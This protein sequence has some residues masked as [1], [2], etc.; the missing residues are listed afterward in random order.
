MP[1]FTSIRVAAA[2]ATI[3]A[4]LTITLAVSPA[5]AAA[6]PPGCTQTWS[7]PYV[8][9][10]GLIKGSGTGNCQSVG[11][12]T[13]KVELVHDFSSPWPDVVVVTAADGGYKIKYATAYS[14]CDNGGTTTYYNH[15]FF[16][17]YAGGVSPRAAFA[18]C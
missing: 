17:G 16:T 6:T 15:A 2:T 4:G 12:R 8:S 13:L 7:T 9:S 11:S 5:F 14:V 3:I 1:R 10:G 18:H